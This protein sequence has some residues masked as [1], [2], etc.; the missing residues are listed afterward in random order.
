M[1]KLYEQLQVRSC[2]VVCYFYTKNF[3]SY[4]VI[5]LQKALISYEERPMIAITKQRLDKVLFLFCGERQ[6]IL[7]WHYILLPIRKRT[8]LLAQPTGTPID[9]AEYGRL[10]EYYDKQGKIR[11]ASGQRTL[12][13][14]KMIETWI[15][16]QYG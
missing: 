7:L 9:L 8:Q 4:F 14:P 13:P 1:A 10:V 16:K 3:D 11:T 5:C 15:W 2:F 12:N 6:G